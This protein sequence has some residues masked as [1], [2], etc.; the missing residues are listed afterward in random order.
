MTTFL[1]R[2]I[3]FEGESLGKPSLMRTLM[4]PR[5]SLGLQ[6]FWKSN[7]RRN[8]GNFNC[9]SSPCFVIS[10]GIEESG[11]PRPLDHGEK[12]GDWGSRQVL[13]I[14]CGQEPNGWSMVDL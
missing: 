2:S 9:S 8:D 12:E 1:T 11:Y 14:R 5:S 3:G 13:A 6:W 4:R 7:S 10:S